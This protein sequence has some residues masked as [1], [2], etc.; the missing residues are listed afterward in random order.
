MVKK[1]YFWWKKFNSKEIWKRTFISG[2]QIFLKS[3]ST[4]PHNYFQY[5]FF[6]CVFIINS[7][8]TTI[9]E[10]KIKYIGSQ[11]II[12][13]LKHL[14]FEKNWCNLKEF[15]SQFHISP[16]FTE[17]TIVS[18]P[19]KISIF[20]LFQNASFSYRICE[21]YRQERAGPGQCL[22]VIM[23]KDTM[24]VTTIKRRIFIFLLKLFGKK[25]TTLSLA[26]LH[27]PPT[28]ETCAPLS[29][30]SSI[31]PRGLPLPLKWHGRFNLHLQQWKLLSV[32]QVQ[33]FSL[34]SHQL[35]TRQIKLTF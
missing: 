3:K 2:N 29:T 14:N 5:F 31:S 7:K 33:A 11:N 35:F 18:F 12:F 13:S 32:P 24:M 6:H 1:K 22:H 30:F 28:L 20:P 26:R 21:M 23:Q 9:S 25:P 16:I 34:A 19:N 27:G 17:K 8:S 10:N 15:N 4:Y